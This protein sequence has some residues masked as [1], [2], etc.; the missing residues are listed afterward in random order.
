VG[1]LVRVDDAGPAEALALRGGGSAGAGGPFEAVGTLHLG[2]QRDE[3]TTSCAIGSEGL[4]E[5]AVMG[6]ARWRI[7]APRAARSWIR[8]RVSRTVR[9]SL[10][11]VWTTMTSPSR[12]YSITACKPGRLVVAPTSCRRRPAQA[13]SLPPRA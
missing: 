11:R 5:S 1:E 8:F 4:E 9:P 7:P 12:A 10:S 2:E 6:S 13:G 3:A